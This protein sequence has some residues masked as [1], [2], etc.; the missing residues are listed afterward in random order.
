M[1]ST[2]SRSVHVRVVSVSFVLAVLAGLFATG[3]AHADETAAVP[4]AWPTAWTEYA[5]DG[6]PVRDANGDQKPDEVDIASG[7]CTADPCTGA[8]SVWYAATADTVFFRLRLAGDPY[9]PAKRTKSGELDQFTYFVQLGTED[10]GVLAVVGADGK[11][12]PDSV[13]VSNGLGT[14]TAVVHSGPFDAALAGLRTVPVGEHFYLDFQVPLATLT[15]VTGVTATTP[16]S[17]FFA[18][19]TDK[20]LDKIGKDLMS[21]T[22]VT[23]DDDDGITLEPI[24]RAPVA[25]ADT[26]SV[27]EDAS[28]T[29]N[30]LTNDTDADVGDVLSLTEI[31]QAPAHGSTST[32][33]GGITYTPAADWNGSDSLVYEV[34][35]VD[36][37]CD[38][39]TVAIT[40]AP[41]NDAPIVTGPGVDLPVGH[42]GVRNTAVTVT[43]VD[44]DTF[45]FTIT[46]TD[47]GTAVVDRAGAVVFTATP[48]AV[49]RDTFSVRA[50]DPGGACDSDVVTVVI[51]A[52]APD[53]VVPKTPAGPATPATP[54][55]PS[56]PT[57]PAAPAADPSS[58]AGPVTE[59]LDATARRGTG[60]LASTGA[61]SVPLALSGAL[62]LL[63][64]VALVTT[65]KRRIQQA[66]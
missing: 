39:A 51:A 59:A 2:V 56:T 53:K 23:F 36:G 63:V 45:V 27:D 32:G 49:G 43:D 34:C 33:A 20:N 37:A 50:C 24:N 54:K 15:E 1:P 25:T 12:D 31:T 8:G 18:T 61:D 41:V 42:A 60:S 28:G 57:T 62:L 40:V 9:A 13:Y 6:A 46:G 21:G 14:E 7:D 5:V 11:V 52:V 17:L 64:G 30:V 48:G 35:D 44:D 29:A 38:T 66:G 16:V 55:T 22:A 4:A 3:V 26:L 65:S 10:D 47:K 19:G 58:P